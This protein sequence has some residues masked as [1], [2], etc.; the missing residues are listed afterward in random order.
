[1]AR[2]VHGLPWISRGQ[3]DQ[4]TASRS[5]PSCT[6]NAISHRLMSQSLGRLPLGRSSNAARSRFESRGSPII[7][8][9]QTCVS[10]RGGFVIPMLCYC[11]ALLL[12][13]FN[14]CLDDNARERIT[15]ELAP[16]AERDPR[17]FLACR[18]DPR[19]GPTPFQDDKFLSGATDLIEQSQTL[20]LEK[21]CCY[22]HKSS[23][24]TVKT[25]RWLTGLSTQGDYESGF[26]TFSKPRPLKSRWLTVAKWVTP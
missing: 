15:A 10:R 25:F 14:V 23:L 21:R 1:V 3:T 17:F 20:R 2:L 12:Q 11:S 5:R 13:C 16:A 22:L 19:H 24:Q 7:H 9:T 4:R 6:G 18:N 8:Q 26:Q